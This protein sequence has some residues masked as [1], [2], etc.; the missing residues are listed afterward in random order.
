MQEGEIYAILAVV[1][2][3]LLG[4]LFTRN[5]VR[6]CIV[7]SLACAFL[8]FSLIAVGQTS[9]GADMGTVLRVALPLAFIAWLASYLVAYVLALPIRIVRTQRRQKESASGVAQPKD[10]PLSSESAPCASSDEVS[11]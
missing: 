3:Y 2:C 4:H 8:V 9:R 5:H 6:V 1:A 10:R 11:S 7:T